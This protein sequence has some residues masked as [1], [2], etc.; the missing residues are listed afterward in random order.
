MAEPAL[1]RDPTVRRLAI[2]AAISAVVLWF[3]LAQF[4]SQGFGDLE[5]VATDPDGLGFLLVLLSAV[6]L[7]WRRRAPWLVFGVTIAASL[8]LVALGYG[9]HAPMA[10]AVGLYT[11]ASRTDR[12]PIWTP[13]A[14]AAVGYAA[15]VAIQAVV[16]ELSVERY[17]VTG[18]LW[19]AAWPIGDRQRT[20]RLREAEAAE[21]V[22]REQRLAHAEERTRIARDHH[23][24]AGHAISNNLVQAGAA[25]VLL[26]R[27]PERSREALAAIEQVAR[28]T[29]IDVERIVGLLREDEQAELAP[30]PGIDDIPSLVET[31]RGA[32]LAF[33][34]RL[35]GDGPSDPIPPEVSRSAYRIAQEALTNAARHGA[36]SAEIAVRRG[37]EA[38]ELTVTNPVPERPRARPGG[39]RGILGMR[40]R[41]ALLGGT[42]DAGP[43]NGGWRLRAVLPYARARS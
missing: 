24:T 31:H 6:P 2:D 36:G 4:G 14:A 32:G 40:E 15:L 35:D 34:G 13:I 9:V 1:I 29:L 43:E 19:A 22:E 41:A 17:V 27:D 7:M 5:G 30:L 28:E 3:T 12:G 21:R 39:G 38:V 25:R 8:A 11:L 26:D 37:P 42:L 23:D 33:Q 20:R 16:L 10:P 18:L